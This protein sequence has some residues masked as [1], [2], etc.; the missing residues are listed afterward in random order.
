[1]EATGYEQFTENKPVANALSAVSDLVAL[2]K[3]KEGELEQIGHQLA[4][5]QEEL[6]ILNQVQLVNLMEELKLAEFTTANGVK[7][8]MDEIIEAGIS[9]ERRYEAHKWL[10]DNGHGGMI[11]RQIGVDFNK[12]QETEAQ[13]LMVELNKKYPA[14]TEKKTV[15]HSTLKAWCREMLKEGKNFPLETFGVFRRKVAKITTAAKKK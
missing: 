3:D 5:K 1:M 8:T 15:H 14:V 11:K 6:R 7:V 10:D 2:I 13:Q 9:E 4:N 12:G